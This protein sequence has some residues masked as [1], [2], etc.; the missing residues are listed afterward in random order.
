MEKTAG[1]SDIVISVP[2][3][4]IPIANRNNPSEPTEF[5]LSRKKDPN[6]Y[7]NGIGIAKMAIPDTYQDAV[8]LV[9]NSIDEL[10]ERNNLSPSEINR[11]EIGT[12][13]APDK[14]K[15]I[16][17]YVIGS[18]E[19][20]YGEGSL[21]RCASPQ[22]QAACASPAYG[23][24][25]ALDWVWAG[26][27]NG[28][29]RIVC[30]ADITRYPLKNGSG[31]PQEI[32]GEHTQGAAAAAI[33]IES[34]PKLMEFDK[35]IGH[36]NEDEDSFFRPD[37]SKVP[38]GDG[39]KTEKMYLK[40]MREAFTHYAEQAAASGLIKLK[41][42]EALTDHFDLLSFHQPFPKM[43]ENG[44]AALLIHEYRNLPRWQPIIRE[45]G[46]EPKSEDF[47]SE[48]AFEQAR[49]DFRK[50]FRMTKT[51]QEVFQSK[52]ADGREA[53][54]EEGNSYTASIWNHLVSLLSIK[55][56]RGEDL[57]GKKGGMGFFG[58]GCVA[59]GQSYTVVPEYQR[60]V[61]SFNLM[62]KLK[63]R[64]AISLQDYED[65]HESR[66]LSGGR[67]FILPPKNEFVLTEIKNGYRYYDF[68]D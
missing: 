27:S 60:A 55:D 24:E 54:I 40:A 56:G 14:S 2:R 36:Y 18:L 3:L 16:V 22:G 19:K 51:F 26:R 21:K 67:E 53:S 52:M 23:V 62:E 10:M 49:D 33:L 64:T 1:I 57:R 17:N 63:N 47:A 4:Y 20:K 8:V 7:L 11:I 37:H 31:Q 15:S 6:Y 9:A 65:L 46:S 30:G 32:L 25:N 42:G 41:E 34:N 39:K 28:S 48:I 43:T 44:L 29:C 61:K 50:R 5:S 35:I 12:E 13:S 45:I 58:S 59:I 38:L 66:P 68:V